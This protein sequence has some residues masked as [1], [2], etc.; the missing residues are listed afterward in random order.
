MAISELF[1]RLT[2]AGNGSMMVY[3]RLDHDLR[4]RHFLP[5]DLARVMPFKPENLPTYMSLFSIPAQSRMARQM[6]DTLHVC[7]PR[8]GPRDLLT[9][10]ASIESML[11]FSTAHLPN[12]SS[13]LTP[14]FTPPSRY[15]AR[16]SSLPSTLSRNAISCHD[17][18][19][20][21]LVYGCH[22]MHNASVLT[23]PLVRTLD[24]TSFQGLAVCHAD[25]TSWNPDHP[26]FS[27]LRAQ[28]GDGTLCHWIPQN[29]FVWI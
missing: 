7:S 1:F 11:D 6:T 9:C 28:P 20:P 18:M 19:F 14:S 25:T 3:P 26:V 24:N 4:G 13:V 12:V 8:P 10:H 21:Y 5:A 2:A 23:V 15:E 17:T 22:L 16:V 29:N 27:A